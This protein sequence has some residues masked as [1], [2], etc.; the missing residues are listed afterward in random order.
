MADVRFA[1]AVEDLGALE[2]DRYPAVRFLRR[3]YELRANVTAYDA[4]YV[5]LA[6]ALG[7]ELWTAAANYS[8]CPRQRRAAHSSSW[9]FAGSGLRDHR[10][11]RI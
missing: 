3:G 2:V 4:E 10:M 8:N 5:A 7:C 9:Y 11:T 1:A 6:E